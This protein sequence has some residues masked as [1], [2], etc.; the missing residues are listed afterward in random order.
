MPIY[1]AINLCDRSW[2]T[3]EQSNGDDEGLWGWRKYPLKLWKKVSASVL[4]KCCK[5]RQ[6]VTESLVESEEG[7]R[8]SVAQSI[9]SDSVTDVSL[10][11]DDKRDYYYYTGASQMDEGAMKWL[12]QY[13][14]EVTI[15]DLPILYIDLIDI[16]H[17]T[18]I[19]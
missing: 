5:S 7:G 10:N 2:G 16:F 9:A 8:E 14:S 1:S 18:E 19:C 4:S 13:K 17:L 11:L 12:R 3:R 15:C 6:E